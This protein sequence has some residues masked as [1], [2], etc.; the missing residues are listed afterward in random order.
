MS[1]VSYSVRAVERTLAILKC[2]NLNRSERSYQEI[3]R[4]IGVPESTVFKLMK[5]LAQEGFL[6]EVDK[7]VFRIGLQM[8]RLGSLYI[9]DKSLVQTARPW[10][11]KLADQ[12]GMTANL[13]VRHNADNSR[14][15]I[16]QGTSPLSLSTRLGE[17]MPYTSSAL[18]KALVLDLPPDELERILPP[19]PWPSLTKTSITSLPQLIEELSLSRERGYTVD[20]EEA[21]PGNKCFGAPVRDASGEIV[22]AISVTGT[23][24]EATPEAEP[25]I[26]QQVIEVARCISEEL[27]YQCVEP[28]LPSQ[29]RPVIRVR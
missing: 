8:Y 16:E 2:F 21:V 15:L 11:R 4:E 7:G 22:A 17:S 29:S 6:S 24:L 18:A 26:V 25:W 20:N 19:P 28:P 9:T 10:L 23:T 14:I 27:G 1:E 5:L 12:T 13:G 3:A